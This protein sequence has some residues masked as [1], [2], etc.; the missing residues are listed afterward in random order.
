[1]NWVTSSPLLDK[2]YD[3]KPRNKKIGICYLRIVLLDAIQKKHFLRIQKQ[4]RYVA[5]V[6]GDEIKNNIHYLM[7]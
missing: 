1:M 6:Y 3:I 4:T 2:S 5:V 7:K